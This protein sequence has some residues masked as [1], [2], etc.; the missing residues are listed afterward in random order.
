LE[1]ATKQVSGRTPS[2]RE[3]LELHRT[4]PLCS[5]CHDRMDPLGLALENFNALGLYRE[6]RPDR[7]IDAS[8]Q[9][10]TGETFADVG[11]LKRILVNERRAD[12]YR[13]VTEKL[14]T[15]AL[16]RGLDYHD[17]HTVD[18]IVEGVEQA[19][20]RFSALLLGTIESA[21]FQKSRA[22]EFAESRDE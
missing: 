1:E 20:G 8:G 7:P 2:L 21:P 18:M 4:R 15:Y 3:A 17:A 16:G 12:F 6:S 9:L 10:I 5:S 19:G 14:L 11:E 22:T 13:C